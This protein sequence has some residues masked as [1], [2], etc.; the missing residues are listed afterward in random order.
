MPCAE[1]MRVQAYFD[2]E[3]DAVAAADIERHIAGCAECRALLDDLTTLRTALRQELTYETARPALRAR[4]MRA[5]DAQQPM[6]QRL[7]P[8]W[9]GAFSGIVGTAL[10]A[11]LAF[12]LLAPPLT[13]PLL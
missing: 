11:G 7:Q 5:L 10:G 12:F 4:V 6:K 3:A 8:F 1:A 2:G 13:N 9:K